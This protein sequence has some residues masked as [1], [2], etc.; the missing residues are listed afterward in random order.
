MKQYCPT[1]GAGIEYSLTKPKFC[2]SCGK[3]FASAA[4]LPAKRVFRTNPVN[5]V[6]MVQEEE[7]EEEFEAPDISKLQFDLE[8][9]SNVSVNKIQDIVATNSDQ[10][11][12]NYQR[13]VDVSYSKETF[14]EDFLKDA[15]SN[16]RP[17][18]ET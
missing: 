12:E 17:N 8:G 15:G 16:R 9:L 2:K 3:A 18:A 1:C 7:P 10:P 6:Q 13:E 11:E 4:K 14:A 5:P